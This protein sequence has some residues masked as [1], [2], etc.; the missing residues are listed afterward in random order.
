MKLE[1]TVLEAWKWFGIHKM[2]W[3]GFKLQD[4]HRPD[5]HLFNVEATPTFGGKKHAVTAAEKQEN[6]EKLLHSM[7]TKVFT[8]T[9]K[10]H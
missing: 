9:Y 6:T 10:T 3:K 2:F 1:K 5:Q 8:S 7:L 4:M